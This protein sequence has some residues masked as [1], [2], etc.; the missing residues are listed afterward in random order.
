MNSS[1]EQGSD[2]NPAPATGE[3]KRLPFAGIVYIAFMR[4]ALLFAVAETA[5]L[6]RALPHVLLSALACGLLLGAVRI[7]S[8]HTELGEWAKWLGNHLEGLR[9]DG[10]RLAWDPPKRLPYSAHFRGFRVNFAAG[11]DFDRE[12][13]LGPEQQGIWLSPREV[14]YWENQPGGGKMIVPVIS[15]GTVRGLI[16]LDPLIP[17]DE[18]L[19]SQQLARRI[20]RYGML[21]LG[22]SGFFLNTVQAVGEVLFYSALF[23][24]LPLAMR[25]RWRA[26][27]AARAFC[28]YLY[29]SLVPLIVATV[30]AAFRLPLIDFGTTFAMV[31]IAYLV[32]V[33]LIAR[34]RL[35]E[36][37]GGPGG[38]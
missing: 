21:I 34:K 20:R 32:A 3:P 15:G 12:R 6:R 31:F 37:G 7:P 33:M 5:R 2:G 14:V 29:F 35:T 13:R 23:A 26:S 10:N 18:V 22:V 36:I 30:Y 9:H 24:F 27:T 38:P 1:P 17:P 19:T 11:E 28:F 25:G 8:L 4:P 16:P